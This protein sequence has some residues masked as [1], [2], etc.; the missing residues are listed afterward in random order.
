MIQEWRQRW[1]KGAQQKAKDII[2]RLMVLQ[3]AREIIE[4][5]TEIDR[6]VVD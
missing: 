1:F 6:E 3:R 5:E 2:V 4:R